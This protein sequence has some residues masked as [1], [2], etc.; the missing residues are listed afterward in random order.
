VAV[1]IVSTAL[2]PAGTIIA[3]AYTATSE[4]A[5]GAATGFV[6]SA[7]T[8]EA[9]VNAVKGGAKG[10]VN[11]A[12]SVLVGE[13]L[14]S[15]CA[16]GSTAIRTVCSKT[17]SKVIHYDSSSA[18]VVNKLWSNFSSGKKLSTGLLKTP[19]QIPSPIRLRMNRI[20]SAAIEKR[21][22]EI[23]NIKDVIKAERKS[24]LF[25][26]AASGCKSYFVDNK[27]TGAINDRLFAS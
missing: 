24:D 25:W 2:G 26:G 16:V 21:A 7:S 23:S 4:G 20:N 18:E 12:V 15:A 6:N 19:P 8:A 10:A 3:N 14:N 11:G 5:A 13:G 22:W 17:P 1:P 9:I 27:V